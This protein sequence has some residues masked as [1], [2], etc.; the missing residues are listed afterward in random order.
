M[1]HGVRLSLCSKTT[2]YELL[3]GA[4]SSLDNDTFNKAIAN[5]IETLKKDGNLGLAQQA[6][7]AISKHRIR[8]LTQVNCRTEMCGGRGDYHSDDTYSPMPGISY[9]VTDRYCCAS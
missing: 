6:A 5:A 9:P 7:A 8:Q 1:S 4:Y 2:A 3:A